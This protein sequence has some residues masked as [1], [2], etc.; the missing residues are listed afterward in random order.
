MPEGTYNNDLLRALNELPLQEQA[1]PLSGTEFEHILQ[2]A[3]ESVPK[4]QIAPSTPVQKEG[5]FMIKHRFTALLIAAAVC[6][7]AVGAAAAGYFLT[8]RQVAEHFDEPYLGEAFA[9]PDALMLNETQ[10]DGDYSVTLLGLLNST[11]L[12]RMWA[13]NTPELS[14]EKTYAVI[15]LTNADGSPLSD[16]AAFS[17][18]G[19]LDY[20]VGPLI[21]GIDPRFCNPCMMNLS[22]SYAAIEGVHYILMDCDTIYPFADRPLYLMVQGG[23]FPN[24]SAY[25]YDESTGIISP[26]PDFEG[27]NVLFTLPIDAAYADTDRAEKLLQKWGVCIPE[28]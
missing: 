1:V 24:F 18:A 9:G 11:A 26:N 25:L 28:T 16:S 15:A 12:E 20:L 27:L 2:R 19:L 13:E 21:G 22:Y 14:P 5:V 3:L 10:T 4:T 23:A 17:S 8:P 6:L 7:F